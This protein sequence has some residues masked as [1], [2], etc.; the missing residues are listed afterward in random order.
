MKQSLALAALLL[1]VACWH[2][3]AAS[4]DDLLGL[5]VHSSMPLDA[6][7]FNGEL[8]AAYA[9]GAAWA[10]DPVQLLARFLPQTFG[11]QTVWSLE[12]EGEHLQRVQ[13]T[14]VV[15]GFSDDSVRGERYD[16]TLQALGS[17][18]W[19]IAVASTSRRCWRGPIDS[20]SSDPCP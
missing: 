9:Q 18:G 17:G 12:G 3:D 16:V 4:P 15:D 10:D 19:K 11:R 1:T 6:T 8:K 13:A 20:Y 2:G 14:I 5:P 7:A